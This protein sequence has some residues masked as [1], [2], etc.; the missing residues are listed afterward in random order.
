MNYTDV[1]EPDEDLVDEPDDEQNEDMLEAARRLVASKAADAADCAMLLDM[2]GLREES[3]CRECSERMSRPD[4][5]GNRRS[6]GGDGLCWEC[7]PSTR[8]PVE[9]VYC[10]CGRSIRRGKSECWTCRNTVPVED[11]VSLVERITRETGEGLRD[12][13]S[14]ARLPRQSLATSLRPGKNSKRIK[15][16]TYLALLRLIPEQQLTAEGA[17]Q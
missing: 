2:L 9:S 5:S 14:R 1:Y 8:A 3:A 17:E 15:R 12:L 6:Q 11:V 7:A 4:K 16:T 13:A 10:V